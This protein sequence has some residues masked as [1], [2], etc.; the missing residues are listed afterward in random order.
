M[1][2][3]ELR[4]RL[5]NL[6][7]RKKT[8]NLTAIPLFVMLFDWK[9]FKTEGKK[10]SCMLHIHPNIAEDEFIKDK[11]QEIVDHVRD[12]YEMEIFTKI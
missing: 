3:R 6:Y 2:L 11:L 9:K 4:K 1:S 12:N 7:I 10:N 5:F 8:K